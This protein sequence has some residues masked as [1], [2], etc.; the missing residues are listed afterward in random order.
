VTYVMG[1]GPSASFWRAWSEKAAPELLEDFRGRQLE[2]MREVRRK[3]GS[4]CGPSHPH[5][6]DMKFEMN[7]ALNSLAQHIEEDHAEH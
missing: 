4:N 2:C 1:A 5:Y 7:T 6:Y 3:Y